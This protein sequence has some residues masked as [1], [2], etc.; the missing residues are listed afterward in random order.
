MISFVCTCTIYISEG[1]KS[2]SRAPEPLHIASL[3]RPFV[4][5]V[6]QTYYERLVVM[7]EDGDA[8]NAGADVVIKP[9]Q[10]PSGSSAAT[11]STNTKLSAKA[12]PFLS[13]VRSTPSSQGIYTQSPTCRIDAVATF[14][15]RMAGCSRTPLSTCRQALQSITS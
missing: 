13:A 9:S 5:S 10:H 15:Q 11:L 6:V 4:W 1:S 8:D 14:F 12:Q 7:T 2:C 3:C